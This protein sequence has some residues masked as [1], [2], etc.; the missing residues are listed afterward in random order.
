MAEHEA[1]R[2]WFAV[3]P[4][5][6]QAGV[7]TAAP[8][9]TPTVPP[10]AAHTAVPTPSRTPTPAPTSEAT[11]G[12]KV[13]ADIRQFALPNLT[14]DAST[15]VTW[16]NR[17]AAPHTNTS[18]TGG[19]FAGAGWDSPLLGQGDSFGYAFAEAGTFSY[20]CRV[21]PSMSGAVTVVAEGGSS[22]TPDVATSDPAGD[23]AYAD[24]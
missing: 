13:Q 10:T 9:P 14:V 18:G 4:S 23:G 21:H 1:G 8:A 20:T 17:D 11:A 2:V 6:D 16:T 3:A 24:Y 5:G 19:V 22:T 15:T 12:A 7:A